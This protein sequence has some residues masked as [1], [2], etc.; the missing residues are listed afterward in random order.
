[1]RYHLAT[2]EVRR[3]LILPCAA[4]RRYCLSVLPVMSDLE[5]SVARLPVTA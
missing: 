5:K 4:E 1:M 2:V 3:A